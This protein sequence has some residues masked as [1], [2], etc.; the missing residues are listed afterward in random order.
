LQKGLL[1][2]ERI[3]THALPLPSYQT[4][5]ALAAAGDEAIK[6]TLAP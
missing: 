6:V 3:V 1:P 4:A 5:F 2:V